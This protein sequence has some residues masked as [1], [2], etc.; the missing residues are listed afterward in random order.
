VHSL[1][2]PSEYI[3]PTADSFLSDCAR[4]SYFDVKGHRTESHLQTKR[5]ARLVHLIRNPLHNIV[6]RYHLERRHFVLKNHSLAVEFPNDSVGF[7]KWCR[8]LDETYSEE[9]HDYFRKADPKLLKLYDKV[10]CH[11][12]FFKYTQWHNSVHNMLPLL[13]DPPLLTVFYEDYQYNF[14]HNVDSLLQFV[15]QPYNAS[16]LRE[17]RALP[18]YEEYF[19]NEQIRAIHKLINHV[20]LPSV[21]PMLQRY[22]TNQTEDLMTSE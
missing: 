19:S 8:I 7:Q 5:V 12:E 1:R 11:A 18:L 13:H 21:Y 9:E 3:V 2:G 22:F 20:A 10:P 17:F 6:A 14:R 4:T 16:R 15:V